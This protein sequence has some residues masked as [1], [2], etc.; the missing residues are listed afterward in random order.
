[1]KAKSTN[2]VS[3]LGEK[4]TAEPEEFSDFSFKDIDGVKVLDRASNSTVTSILNW[5]PAL[6]WEITQA[7]T[8]SQVLRK[9]LKHTVGPRILRDKFL[10]IDKFCDDEQ[11]LE[12]AC[13]EPG[14]ISPRQ[15][16]V[17]IL[18]ERLQISPR[19]IERYFR[20]PTIKKKE[21]FTSTNKVGKR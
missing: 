16:A 4:V 21:S 17:H 19:T 2:R 1:M 9:R 11:I 7:M 3:R 8:Y 20:K 14:M 12:I 6:E 18:S 10:T 15:Q 13:S 5:G